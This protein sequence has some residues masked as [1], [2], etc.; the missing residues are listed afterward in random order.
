MDMGPVSLSEP[1][2][3]FYAQESVSSDAIVFYLW[4]S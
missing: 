2:F 3:C 4:H 1:A